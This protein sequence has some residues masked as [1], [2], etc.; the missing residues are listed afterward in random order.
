MALG[1]IGIGVFY[2]SKKAFEILEPPGIGSES[3]TLSEQNI[4]AY[5]DMPV[6]FRPAFVTFLVEQDLKHLCA[7][8]LELGLRG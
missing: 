2:C 3:A 4:I 6:G 5:L 7:T 8:S 1:P